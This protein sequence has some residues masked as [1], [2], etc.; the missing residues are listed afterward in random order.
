[1]SSEDGLTGWERS[2]LKSLTRE[3]ICRKK[4]LTREETEIFHTLSGRG[5]KLSLTVILNTYLMK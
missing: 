1:M 4:F 3:G 5:P 2:Q